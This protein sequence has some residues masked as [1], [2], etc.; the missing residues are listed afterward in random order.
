MLGLVGLG[1]VDVF[2]FGLLLV[3][4]DFF[5]YSF[6]FGY[7]DYEKNVIIIENISDS[8]VD[9]IIRLLMDELF[10]FQFVEVCI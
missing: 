5:Y 2:Y 10:R 9:G 8:F 1:V 6:E 4:F 3:V 7:L